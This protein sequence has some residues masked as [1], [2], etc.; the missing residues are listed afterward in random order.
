MGDIQERIESQYPGKGLKQLAEE[1]EIGTITLKDILEEIRKPA[2]DPREDAPAVIFRNDVR[3]FEDLKVD[4]EL[5][6]T[7]RNV[8]DFGAFVDIGLEN[9]GLIHISEISAGRVSHPLEALSV[10][11]YLPRI[12]IL[13]I[14][15]ETGK[16]GLSLKPITIPR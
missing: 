14:N 8:V 7:V 4:M 12:R 3:N 16:V 13:S 6:G 9:D 2:R 15:R 11:Q 10:N 1:L 5:Q